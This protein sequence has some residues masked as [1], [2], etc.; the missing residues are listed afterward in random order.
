MMRM[1]KW[2]MAL[3]VLVLEDFKTKGTRCFKALGI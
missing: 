2:V 3:V 1:G